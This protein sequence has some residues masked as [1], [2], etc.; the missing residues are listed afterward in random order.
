MGRTCCV[1]LDCDTFFSLS[2]FK[3]SGSLKKISPL[4]WGSRKGVNVRNLSKA[5]NNAGSFRIWP[6]NNKQLVCHRSS[7]R[8]TTPSYALAGQVADEV[9][10]GGGW[11]R[12]AEGVAG[13]R[14]G[15]GR[16]RDVGLG[17]NDDAC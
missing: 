5:A 14:V 6:R 15:E 11:Q 13:S 17:L 3:C 16:E 7:E 2:L 4:K 8:D 10:T 9:G 1:L 12:D